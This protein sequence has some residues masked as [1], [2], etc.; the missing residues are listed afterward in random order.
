MTYSKA[1][2][3]FS[4]QKLNGTPLMPYIQALPNIF[5]SSL[6]HP[7][8]NIYLTTEMC[9]EK[10]CQYLHLTEK[11]TEARRSRLTWPGSRST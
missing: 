4:P 10:L 11:D 7:S 9:R 1:G 2:L 8:L 6:P 3:A 5:Q